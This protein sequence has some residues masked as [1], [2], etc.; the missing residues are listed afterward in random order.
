MSFQGEAMNYEFPEIDDVE[1][2][3]PVVLDSRGI[4]VIRA[5]MRAELVSYIAR[6]TTTSTRVDEARWAVGGLTW[7][8]DV[9]TD[10]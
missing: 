1:P 6:N 4:V 3:R 5:D 9:D 10:A 8:L 7:S 2:V